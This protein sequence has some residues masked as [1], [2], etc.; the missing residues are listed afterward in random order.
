MQKKLPPDLLLSEGRLEALL[1][2][3]LQAQVLPAI[4][5]TNNLYGS[6]FLGLNT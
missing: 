1:E 5:H 4:I 2:Q 3:A 6:V